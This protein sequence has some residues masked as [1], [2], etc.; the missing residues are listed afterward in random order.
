MSLFKKN[1]L[2]LLVMAALLPAQA[3]TSAQSGPACKGTIYLTF[4]TGSQSQADLIAEVLKRHHIKATFF[5]A[6]EKTTRGDYSLDPAWAP[7]WKAR[8]AEGHAFGSHTFDHVYWQR[9]QANGLMNVKPQFG[10]DGGK[11]QQWSA[12]Q[13]CE[14]IQRVDQRF[15]QLTGSKLD[16]LWRA[17]GGKIS[18]LTLAAG[19]ACGYQHVAWAPAGFSGDELSS[20]KYPNAMLLKRALA[21]LRDG[22]IFIAHMG[23]WSRKDPWAPANLEALIVG[24]EQKGFC[25]ATMREHPDYSSKVTHP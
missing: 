8:V 25:F 10:K 5:L 23:I 13:Y 3:A 6:N 24:L 16:P 4:D 22:D 15:Q 2:A 21:N 19:K 12:A 1:A 7:Y 14:E 9:D 18:P 11:Q 20:E 17:P